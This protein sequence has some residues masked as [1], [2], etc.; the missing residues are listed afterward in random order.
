M[1]VITTPTGQIGHQVLD[2]ILD[3]AEAI[4]VIVRDPSRLSPRVRERVEIVQG[5]HGDLDVVTR[6]FAG[7]DSVF[8]LVPPNPQAKSVEDAYV[9]FT[10]PACEAIKS[11]GVRRVVAISTLGRG[12]AKN[13]GNISAS[14]AMDE[15]IESTGVSYRALCPPT[16]TDNLLNQ[17]GTIKSLGMFFMPI[18]ADHVLRTCA[19]CDIAAAATRLLLDDSWSG[20]E[21]V[22]VMGPDDL[23]PDD[24]ARIIS[25]V[26]GRPVRFQQT[27][28]ETFKARLIEHG[29]SEAMVQGM[30]DM[31]VAVDQ[32]LYNHQPRTTQSTTP[33]S[34][35]QWCE[36][37]LKLVVLA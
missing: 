7:A 20:Q 25:E 8:W 32:G 6:A 13:A 16:F 2:N 21:D 11:L 28:G 22:P 37:V 1:I 26:L 3:N 9:G 23:S 10:R 5:S 15:L 34:F 4:R 18:T 29:I 12:I 19:T 36:E 35:R 31:M 30:L 14:L 17:V 24:M 27:P 33:T